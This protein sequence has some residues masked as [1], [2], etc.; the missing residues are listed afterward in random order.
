MMDAL[1]KRRRGRPPLAIPLTSAER[2][3][4]RRTQGFKSVQLPPDVV[5]S[6]R[7]LRDRDGDPTDALAIKRAVNASLGLPMP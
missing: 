4:A 1:P 7:T 2:S 5:I 6:L 3:K